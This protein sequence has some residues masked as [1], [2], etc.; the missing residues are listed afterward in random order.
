MKATNGD[1]RRWIA[2]ARA[3]S[4]EDFGRLMSACRTY[5]LLVAHHH[6][7][8]PILA[9]ADASDLVQETFLEAQR[10]FSSF[11]G[12]TEVEL[13]S[14]LRKILTNHLQDLRRRYQTASKRTID[15]EVSLDTAIDMDTSEMALASRDPSPSECVIA[16]EQARLL[17][18]AINR[19]P[20]VDQMLVIYRH[21]EGLEFEQIAARISKS[22]PAVRKRWARAIE[23]L[24]GELRRLALDSR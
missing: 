7:D 18:I 16:S 14:W 11:R 21:K 5:L 17:S 23:R 4:A 9:K 6:I 13:R 8:G 1:V 15:R 24:N 2:S 22:I 20:K 3:G 19:L 12:D 10:G